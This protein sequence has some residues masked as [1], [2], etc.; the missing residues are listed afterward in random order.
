M[1]F[2]A[3]QQKQ[4]V[5]VK[6]NIPE[7]KT[8]KR[9][10]TKKVIIESKKQPLQ[11]IQSQRPITFYTQPYL[12]NSIMEENKIRSQQLNTLGGYNMGNLM[13]QQR[14]VNILTNDDPRTNNN[15]NSTFD[16]DEIHPRLPIGK[17]G[18]IELNIDERAD[19]A[20]SNLVTHE[21]KSYEGEIVSNALDEQLLE[22]EEN[23]NI[24][25]PQQKKRLSKLNKSELINELKT[26]ILPDIDET[27]LKELM[28]MSRYDLYLE[29]IDIKNRVESQ[30]YN[31]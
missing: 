18:I 20:L 24:R 4:T 2:N 11:L 5:N 14:A 9:R 31:I 16:A 22:E 6:I 23:L 28:K 15:N 8:K 13:N 10:R 27:V 29:V 25:V 3:Q 30:R 1:T 26:Y 12:S 21:R 19:N 7:L 17:S